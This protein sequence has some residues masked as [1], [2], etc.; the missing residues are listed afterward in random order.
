M[1]ASTRDTGR[2][3]SAR[4]PSAKGARATR[5]TTVLRCA[6]GQLVGEAL[7]A[8][9]AAIRSG[10]LIVIPTDTVYGIA[11]N[12]FDPVAIARVYALK[13]REYRKAL[14][15]LLPS[16]ETL[17]LITTEVLP[18]ARRLIRSLWP[19]P[20]TVVV[21]TAPTVMNA[22]RGKETVAVRVPDHGMVLTLLREF[23]LPLAATSANLSGNAAITNG[24]AA[25]DLF[26]GRVEIIVDGGACAVGR[27]STVVETTRF[28]F[29][30][31]RE[32]AVS[33]FELMRILEAR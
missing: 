29:T 1:S 25:V 33:R 4:T 23:G 14:P 13:G 2:K 18:E 31:I 17:P 28:P 7:A 11:C 8:C 30:V 6:D 9:V 3:K 20:L 26:R 10:G 21:K 22:T 15:I 5:R 19:G 24:R 27:E 16:E 12:A 32:G